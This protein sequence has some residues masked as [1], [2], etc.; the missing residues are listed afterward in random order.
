MSKFESNI[1]KKLKKIHDEAATKVRKLLKSK[2]APLDLQCPL[3]SAW[4]Y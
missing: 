4:K 2:K 1:K 3:G